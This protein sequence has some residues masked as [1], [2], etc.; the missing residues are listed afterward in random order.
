MSNTQKKLGKARPPRVQITY[1]VEVGGAQSKKE[2]PLVMGVMGDFAK[3]ETTLRERRFTHIDKDN[4]NDV[5]EGM[6]PSV[7]M[8]VESALPEKE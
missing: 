3:D 1:D 5:M 8:L 6:T 4:F 7:D 2:L